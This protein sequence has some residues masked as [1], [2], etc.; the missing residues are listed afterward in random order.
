M[1][2]LAEKGYLCVIHDHRGHGSSVVSDADLGYFYDAGYDGLIEDAHQ[3]TE[4]I[5]E[6]V[7]GCPIYSDWT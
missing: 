3:V 1:K 5:K 4:M 6:S 7:G 2:Y